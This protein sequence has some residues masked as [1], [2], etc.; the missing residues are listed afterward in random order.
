MFNWL[1]PGPIG[2]GQSILNLSYPFT[3]DKN[4]PGVAAARHAHAQA[5]RDAIRNN[6]QATGTSLDGAPSTLDYL[7]RASAF[8]RD[9]YG[10]DGDTP[11]APKPAAVAPPTPPPQAPAAPPASPFSAAAN[12]IVANNSQ[13]S[14]PLGAPPPPPQA[15]PLQVPA[16]GGLGLFPGAPNSPM[17]WL[18]GA[19]YKPTP[20][21]MHP[22]APPA[23][24]PAVAAAAPSVPLPMARPADAPAP[25]ED[26]GFF[27]RNA[28]MMTDPMTGQLI[29][30]QGAQ[31]VSGPTLI[32]KM[33]GYL[34][35]KVT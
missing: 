11:S 22:T 15:T 35:N 2:L 23:P 28:L 26:T 31:S 14:V 20:P 25:P 33:M 12:A 10:V 32:D 16:L 17:N 1:K 9:P 6:P 34:H 3:Q 5:V 30:P 13:P 21:M 18:Q 7:K 29:D 4:F 19:Q 8:M 27:R 24:A